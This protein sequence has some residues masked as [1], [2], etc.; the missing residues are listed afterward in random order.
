MREINY[1]YRNDKNVQFIDVKFNTMKEIYNFI[2]DTRK[3]QSDIDLTSTVNHRYCVDAKSILGVL[4]LNVASI[5][6]VGI[7]SDDRN[8]INDFLE[9]MKKYEYIAKD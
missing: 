1:N 6:K 5:L 7:I 8:E 9:T 4:S 3:F 2:D